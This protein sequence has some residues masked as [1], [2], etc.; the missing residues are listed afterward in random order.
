[1]VVVVIFGTS[2]EGEANCHNIQHMDK[3]NDYPSEK[4]VEERL[5]LTEYNLSLACKNFTRVML[6]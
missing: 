3:I 4:R 2:R 5:H 1:M 6:L